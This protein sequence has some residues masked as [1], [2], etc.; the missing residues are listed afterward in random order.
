MLVINNTVEDTWCRNANGVSSYI[1]ID[2]E[3][4]DNLL[5]GREYSSKKE[6]LKTFTFRY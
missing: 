3:G 6:K 4:L 5:N 2:E 1:T